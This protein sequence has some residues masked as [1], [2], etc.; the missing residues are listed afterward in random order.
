MS[1]N[2]LLI[3]DSKH[4]SLVIIRE[5]KQTFEVDHAVSLSDAIDL[6]RANQYDAILCDLDLGDS[7]G[8]P[9]FESVKAAANNW[10]PHQ[11]PVVVYSGSASPRL[12]C[13]LKQH[14]CSCVLAKDSTKLTDIAKQ[15][16]TAI[17][18]CTLIECTYGVRSLLYPAYADACAGG[19]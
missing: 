14:G 1:R 18:R 9:T 3:E 17:L 6:I 5:L 7:E 2:V 11:I 16:A 4:Q 10:L 12:A 8:L 13:E 15:L 19:C